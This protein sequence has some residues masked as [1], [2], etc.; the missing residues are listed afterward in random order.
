MYLLFPF[1]TIFQSIQD[2]DPVLRPP[3]LSIVKGPVAM[4]EFMTAGIM[5][6]ENRHDDEVLDQTCCCGCPGKIF[7]NVCP[8]CAAAM[9]M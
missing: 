5:L 4:Q 6:Y 2:F 8:C 7:N 3:V 9:F 1:S